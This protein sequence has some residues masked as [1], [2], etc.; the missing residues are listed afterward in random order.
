VLLLGNVHVYHYY[1]AWEFAL[2]F[3]TDVFPSWE[4]GGLGHS[5]AIYDN[6]NAGL[7]TAIASFVQP[8]LMGNGGVVYN[9]PLLNESN[10]SPT[11]FPTPEPVSVVSGFVASTTAEIF[12]LGLKDND[13]FGIGV[14]LYE[15][16]LAVGA[17]VPGMNIFF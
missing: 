9:I 1:D 8:D 2:V 11:L 15:N 4:Y 10:A 6:G 3:S 12:P 16:C 17:S 7:N 13:M 14:S 5:V